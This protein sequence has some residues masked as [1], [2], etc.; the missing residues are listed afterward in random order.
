MRVEILAVAA[1]LA[2]A[3]GV[4]V[5]QNTPSAEGAREYFIN[6][7]DGQHVTSPVL[8]QFG[9]SG[10]GISPFG[11]TGQGTENTGHHHL[12]IDSPTPQAG[13]PIPAEA[14]KYIHYGRGQTEASVELAP[15]QHTLQL[16]LGDAAHIPHNPP[17][18]SEQI[19]I[20]VDP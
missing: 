2:L 18:M 5:A 3:S 7:E 6:L 20:T 17:V 1:A 13:V 15:G 11:I 4:A 10:M 9:L 19:T 14:G 8:I 12:V 16:V